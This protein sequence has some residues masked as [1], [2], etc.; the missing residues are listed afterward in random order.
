MNRIKI[1]SEEKAMLDQKWVSHEKKDR[2][3]MDGKEKRWR[4]VYY[5]IE[6]CGK[7]GK[8]YEEPRALIDSPIGDG[9]FDL[10]E[11]PLRYLTKI[12][13]SK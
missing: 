12:I 10:R 6:K 8:K 4:I 2:Y 13:E 7:T 1:I 5:P 11:M 9:F 3:T